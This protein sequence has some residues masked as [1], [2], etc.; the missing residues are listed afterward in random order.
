MVY[1]LLADGVV[2]IH[3]LWVLFLIFGAFWGKR[4]RTIREVHITGL[5][6][7]V[8]IETFDWYCPLTHLEFWFRTRHNPLLAYRGSFIVHY[9]ERLLYIECP[10]PLIVLLTIAL[11]SFNVWIYRDKRRPR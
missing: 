8:I 3:F 2:L 5:L 11:C 4:N 7:A 10:R 6:F 9:L 1:M